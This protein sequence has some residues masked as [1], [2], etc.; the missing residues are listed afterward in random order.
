MYRIAPTRLCTL[1]LCC[2][3]LLPPAAADAAVH[4]VPVGGD[5]QA[6]LEIAQPG[7]VILLAA[8]AIYMGNFTLPVKAGSAFISVRTDAPAGDLPAPGVRITPGHAAVLAKLRSPNTRPA[9]TAAPGAHHWRLELLEFQANA[10]GAGDIIVL[11]GA[12]Q[13]DLAQMPHTLII[14]RVYIHGDPVVGQKRGIAL[15][16]GATEITNSHIS[17]IKAVGIDTQAICGWNGS[18]PYLIQNNHLEAAGENI[19]FGGA[20]PSIPGLV[21]S[22]ITIR[23]N[24]LTK[25]LHWRQERWQVKNAFELKNARR[26]LVEGNVFEHVW[27]AAQVG[28]AVQLTTRNQ[29]GG[30]PWSTVED[31]T[32][33]FN[34]VRHA[35]SAINISGFDDARPSRQ[36]SRYR[37]AH[38]VFYDIGSAAWGGSGI[39]LQLGNEPRD[40]VVEHNTVSHTGT[41]VAVYGSRGNAFAAIDGFLFRDNLMRHNRYGI[42][43]DDSGV[44]QQT[45]GTFFRNTV[46][47]RNALAGGDPRNY[48]SGNLFPS[49]AEFDVLFVNAAAG[50]FTLVPGSPFWTAASDGGPL[51]ADIARLNAAVSGAIAPSEEGY[52]VCRPGRFCTPQSPYSRP[53]R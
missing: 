8:G 27:A 28:F 18:G 35:S 9:L 41:V 40:V 44:G 47:D 42:K 12:T 26:V 17:D 13:N 3:T 33:Q 52:A 45:L 14:D 15:N 7:D 4:N 10:N 22:D 20:D 49:V 1:A 30:A 53:R 51:G 23:R 34:I 50:D 2:L 38:N 36:G 32:F 31:V 39:F 46:F 25:A 29:S 11:G 19:M 21:P 24:L 48:P 16:S 37:I 43:G 5:L 6:A